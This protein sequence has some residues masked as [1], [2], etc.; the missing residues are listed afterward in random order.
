MI[1]TDAHSGSA[2]CAPTRY[3][4][5][6]DMPPYNLSQDVGETKN[7]AAEHPE[8]VDRLTRLLERYDA[9]GRS[10]PGSPRV[11]DGPVQIRKPPDA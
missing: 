1:F 5:S 10:T 6:L 4:M 2:V 11:N 3:G 9:E 8:I 7:V